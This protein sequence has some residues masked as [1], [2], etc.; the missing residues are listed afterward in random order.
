M[1]MGSSA[2]LAET[3]PEPPL[4]PNSP[5]V[6]PPVSN[7]TATPPAA[8]PLEM[9]KSL[10]DIQATGTVTVSGFTLDPTSP[11]FHS[12][13][14]VDVAPGAT[15][16][17]G[18]ID[19]RGRNLQIAAG[20]QIAANTF[21]EGDAGRLQIEVLETIALSGGSV[22]GPSGLFAIADIPGS[23]DGGQLAIAAEHLIVEQGAQVLTNS[24]SQG[25]AGSIALQTNRLSLLGT[26]QPIELPSTLPLPD[27]L[28][29]TQVTP[30]L[31]Q[32]GMGIASQGQGG[33][34][35]INTDQL[36]VTDGAKITTGTFGAGDAG[37]LSI[38]SKQITV[39]GFSPVE[40]PS[41]LFTTVDFGAAG[42][43]GKLSIEA[44]RLQVLDG[45]QIAT[46][47]A[48][49]GRA[50]DLMVRSEAVHLSGQTGQG[51]SGLFATAIGSTGAGGNLMVNADELLITNGAALSVSNFSSESSSPIPS[52]QGAAGNLQVSARQT[53][54]RDGSVV[55]ADTV[56][57]DRGNL[58]VQTDLLILRQGSRITTNA[59]GAATGGNIDINATDYVVAVANENSD[60]TANAV[61]GDGGQ[62]NINARSVLGL[63]V[64]P[65]LTDQSDI[66]ASSQFGV[67]GETRLET[68]DSEVRPTAEPLPQSP[69]GSEEVVQGCTPGGAMTG[70]FVES[71]RGGLSARPYGVLN[72]RDSLI[73]LSI[74]SALATADTEAMG[75]QSGALVE[76]QDWQMN[77]QGEVVLVAATPQD[78]G[79][80]CLSWQ[81]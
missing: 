57:G 41:G 6:I 58:L 3:L 63:A 16:Q 60:I 12:Y 44:S 9:P 7:P 50:G 33:D 10:I 14:S 4:P 17:G 13:L 22:L 66:T 20:G 78:G 27:G 5:P 76:A 21:G 68:L 35:T 65:A 24:F 74:P 11:P 28:G 69:Q 45:A 46:S 72:S 61:F 43:G 26:S 49:T 32:S 40:G 15:S 25:A 54:L 34:V 79:T 75:A 39:A 47:T 42:N 29:P 18:M 71:G 77:E 53:T 30:T 19:L 23:G 55:S 51:R 1:V 48:G 73:D 59:T 80:R 67:A 64:R 56:A 31:L 38:V 36:L 37:A 62:V 81:P 8:L 2:I 70:R 52:G